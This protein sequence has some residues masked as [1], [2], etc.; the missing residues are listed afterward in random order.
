MS[1]AKQ[2]LFLIFG[3]LICVKSYAASKPVML[4]YPIGRF[5]DDKP[6]A[7]FRW[8]LYAKADS[9]TIKVFRKNHEGSYDK[10]KN[11]IARFDI[12]SQ[13]MSMSWPHQPLPV[14]NYAWSIEGYDETTPNAL[15][16]EDTN[17]TIEAAS[18]INLQTKRFG[19]QV[20]FGRG[21]YASINRDFDV[22]FNTTP[23]IYGIL[24][25]GG[26]ANGI[27]DLSG[28][29]SDFIL[30]GKLV[31]TFSAHASYAY[32]LN[33]PNSSRTDFFIG[34]SLRTHTFPSVF[35]SDGVNIKSSTMT[36]MS[37][38]LIFS[39]QK[40]LNTKFTLYS[41]LKVDAPVFA[42]KKMTSA[43][44]PTAYSATGGMIFG[45]FWPLAFGAE[46][47]YR[48]DKSLTQVGSGKIDTTMESWALI[49]NLVYTF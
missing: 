46:L 40:L 29:A 45:Y 43:V 34:P 41:H 36:Q 16:Y 49:S 9:L 22:N 38:G 17:F 2:T 5:Q 33:D 27:W 12:S 11:L 37:P 4:E 19:I 24:Y 32:H 18:A 42:S 44:G 47:E 21:Q 39:T 25:R 10:I 3:I 8:T 30:R 23:T 15:F 7:L 14:G 26:N 28:Y 1:F 35:S 20:G 6:P 48:A 13:V 31:Q